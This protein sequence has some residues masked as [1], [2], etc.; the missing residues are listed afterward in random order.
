[1][2]RVLKNHFRIVSFLN[3]KDN[4]F[5]L[6]FDIKLLGKEECNFLKYTDNSSLFVLWEDDAC[7]QLHL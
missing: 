3:D 7:L 1:M 5:I 6:T 2:Q 4:T